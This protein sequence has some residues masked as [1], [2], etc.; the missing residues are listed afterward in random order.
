MDQNTIHGF[1]STVKQIREMYAICT[2]V[3]FFGRGTIEDMDCHALKTAEPNT[4]HFTLDCDQKKNPDLVIDLNS[5]HILREMQ[6]LFDVIVFDW[7]VMKFIDK[8]CG[9]ETEVNEYFEILSQML[10]TDG[11]LIYPSPLYSCST[12]F[13]IH[14][15]T[16]SFISFVMCDKKSEEQTTKSQ[17]F[18][19]DVSNKFNMSQSDFID[20]NWEKSGLS[21]EEF[22]VLYD[23][24]GKLSNAYANECQ[25]KYMQ[26]FVEIVRR[27]NTFRSVLVYNDVFFPY[28]Q[29]EYKTIVYYEMIK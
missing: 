10:T 27:I 14:T 13:D 26:N 2:I 8:L 1:I 6:E 7:N 15:E 28:F 20:Y 25:N 22:E 18:L 5:L 11:K 29:M 9:T 12:N 3:A 17:K 21:E 24:Y 23:E 19:K 4:F 16:Y